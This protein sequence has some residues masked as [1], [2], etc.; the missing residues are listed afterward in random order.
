MSKFSL[1]LLLAAAFIFFSGSVWAASTTVSTASGDV[2]GVEQDGLRVF[3]G[4]PY[5]E[6]P[7]GELR[8]APPQKVKP[9]TAPLDASE[10]GP[11][12]FQVGDGS[13]PMSEDCL[14]LNVWTP[15]QADEKAKLPVY[16]FIHGGAYAIGSGAEPLFDMSSF[17]KNGVVGVTIN[18]RL[19]ALGFFASRSTY[20]KYGTTGNWGHLDQILALEWVR[21][22]IAAFG[23][24]PGNVTI[25]GESAGSFSVSSLILSPLA[26]GLFQ[27]AILE[28]GVVWGAR[29]YSYYAKGDLKRSI[30]LGQ[31]LS[32]IFLAADDAQGLAELRRADPIALAK[33][34]EFRMDLSSL[35]PFF[36][37]PVYDGHVLPVDP[38]EALKAGAFNHVRIL[39][40]FNG[41]EG[42]LFVPETADEP[43]Y[44]AMATVAYGP[45][46]AK[47]VLERFPVDEL[48]PAHRR[49]RQLLAYSLF[50][51]G[52]KTLADALSSRGLDV[53]GYNFDYI[54]P[55][56]QAKGIGAM[57][58]DELAYAF[59]NLEAGGL[60]ASDHQT[61]ADE[62]HLRWVNFI[63]TGDPNQG[64]QLPSNLQW[65]KY[66]PQNSQVMIF[67]SEL[68]VKT[69]PDKDNLEFFEKL[70][71]W[72]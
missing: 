51:S 18:Y 2:V 48:N 43:A 28:S 20:D 37:T 33:L 62:I 26:K 64:L 21:D 69:L 32:S 66:D 15:A 27:G 71:A 3:K 63:K 53:Y 34:A 4:I 57:H 50:T 1:L 16:V 55:E 56:N 23:G 60:K 59:N 68:A 45:E 19:N 61:L 11:W 54:S 31:L 41:D 46:Q 9:W 47:A 29:A 38:L 39:W 42:A 7:E 36:L 30:E 49:V 67:N 35:T 72:R 8:F 70:R 44:A 13:P 52:M 25:G 40:G 17:A 14:S 24:D 58:T 65:P 12:A 6:P 22:N 5:A 10:F